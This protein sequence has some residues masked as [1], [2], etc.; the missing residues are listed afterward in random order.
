MTKKAQ[1]ASLIRR[2]TKQ[3]TR[4]IRSRVGRSAPIRKGAH[5]N[6]NKYDLSQLV[7]LNKK[8]LTLE[9]LERLVVQWGGVV[10]GRVLRLVVQRRHQAGD[11]GAH[12]RRHRLVQ[13]PARVQLQLGQAEPVL[14]ERL[15]AGR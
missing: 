11:G 14:A 1:K 6:A 13:V 9:L 10:E 4:A 15:H 7:Y 2:L 5:S 12:G 3:S 8:K